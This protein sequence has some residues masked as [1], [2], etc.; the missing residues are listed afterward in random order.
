MRAARTTEAPP[1]PYSVVYRASRSGRAH[2]VSIEMRG[3]PAVSGD[4]KPAANVRSS[5]PPVMSGASAPSR[6]VRNDSASQPV[7]STVPP[8]ATNAC[9]ARRSPSDA[10]SSGSARTSTVDG[11][12]T[13]R[14][15]IAS[16]ERLTS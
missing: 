15:A 1:S 13:A 14:L 4:G 16:N 2:T 11:G 6:L 10:R 8:A 9:S 5:K 7:T 12:V 3:A